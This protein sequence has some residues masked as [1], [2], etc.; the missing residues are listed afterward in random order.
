MVQPDCDALMNSTPYVLHPNLFFE[1]CIFQFSRFSEHIEALCTGDNTEA[2]SVQQL[3]QQPEQHRQR[4]QSRQG[5]RHGARRVALLIVL[6]EAVL[7]IVVIVPLGVEL[8]EAVEGVEAE[9]GVVGRGAAALV[10]VGRHVPP[11]PLERTQAVPRDQRLRALGLG[12]LDTDVP[13]RRTGDAPVELW[14]EVP[15]T[16]GVSADTLVAP[17]GATCLN[18]RVSN[19]EQ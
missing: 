11:V 18:L 1:S 2:L 5:R 16:A 15:P 8:L 14:R 13:G 3:D 19:K 9:P 6:A 4:H 17:D 10:V 7:D 12:D